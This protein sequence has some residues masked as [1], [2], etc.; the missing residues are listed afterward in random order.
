MSMEAKI[1][2]GGNALLQ[3]RAILREHLR[4]MPGQIIGNFGCGG[5]GFFTLECARLVGDQGQVYAVDIVK[6]ALSSVDGKAKLQGLYNVKTVWSDLEIYGAT[7][8]PEASLDHGLLVNILFQSKKQ[9]AI[10]RE[11]TRM[12]KPGG[13]L[14]IIDWNDVPVSFGPAVQERVRIDELRALVP[15]L[16]YTEEKLFEAGQYHFGLIFIRI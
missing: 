2:S 5:G 13:K 11:A 15:Q 4:I 10:I 16:G 9:D 6:N 8:I 12:I 3:P 7:D 14:L 1:V